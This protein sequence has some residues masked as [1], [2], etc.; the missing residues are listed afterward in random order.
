[1]QQAQLWWSC[2]CLQE[3]CN[4]QQECLLC[5]KRIVKSVTLALADRV[6]A[7][8]TSRRFTTGLSMQPGWGWRHPLHCGLKG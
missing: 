7:T 8:L 2:W 4:G 1:M 3:C 5:E 6:S